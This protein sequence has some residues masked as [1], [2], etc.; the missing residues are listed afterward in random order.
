MAE[1]VRPRFA[2]VKRAVVQPMPDVDH[3][4]NVRCGLNA[5]RDQ[6][7][8]CGLNAKRDQNARRVLNVRCGL[9]VNVRRELNATRDQIVRHGLNATRVQSATRGLNVG[10]GLNAKRSLNAR[11]DERAQLRFVAM[12][13]NQTHRSQT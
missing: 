10:H 6:N 7:A 11:H 9:R 2:G 4:L 3:D 12:S 1:R 8:R 13:R 5:K